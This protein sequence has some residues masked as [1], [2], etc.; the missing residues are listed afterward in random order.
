[1]KLP[2][3]SRR[4]RL[5]LIVGFSVFF[6]AFSILVASHLVPDEI[7]E[8]ELARFDALIEYRMKPEPRG[9]PSEEVQQMQLLT[10]D[11]D[12]SNFRD[13]AAR[14]TDMK[15]VAALPEVIDGALDKFLTGE[16]SSRLPLVW[17][18][19]IAG[20][21]TVVGNAFGDEPIVA[22]YNPYFDVVILT[23]WR[24]TDEGLPGFELAEAYPCNGRAFVE[25]RASEPRDA[26]LWGG[27]DA[28][29][30]ELGL[31]KG[32]QDFVMAFEERYPPF[33]Q[34]KVD[35]AADA[36]PFDATLALIEDRALYLLKW[37]ND[38]QNPKAEVNYAEAITQLKKALAASGPGK[39]A[40][41]LP[42]GNPQTA[43][44][45]FALEPEIREGLLPYYVIDKTVIFVNPLDITKAFL[46]VHFEPGVA[47]YKPSFVSLFNF[48]AN[49]PAIESAN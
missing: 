20:S 6:L 37:V 5:T 25:K 14:A 31:V 29:I 35:I 46:S 7:D 11:Y 28:S 45:F 9:E 44:L 34:E 26:P 43:E 22:F 13:N 23:K 30:F 12:V 24:F 19:L 10:L 21:V 40:A 42:E 38:A 36:G 8:E 1:M 27:S 33:G 39:L 41:L 17:P 48:E 15:D 2:K 49:Y 32:T 16:V 18:Y 3:I 47:G 4:L